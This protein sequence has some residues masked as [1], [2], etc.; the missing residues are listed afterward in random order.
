MA[1]SFILIPCVALAIGLVQELILLALT[2]GFSKP[3]IHSVARAYNVS[4]LRQTISMCDRR[5]WKSSGLLLMTIA[6]LQVSP[7]T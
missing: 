3:F 6:L 1:L 4:G 7:I 2:N 5:N